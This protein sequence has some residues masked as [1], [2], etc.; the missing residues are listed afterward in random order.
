MLKR[1]PK[2]CFVVGVV[3]IGKYYKFLF[4]LFNFVGA[5]WCTLSSFLLWQV[6]LVNFV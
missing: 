6:H 5:Y 1:E 4:F 3:K 2:L